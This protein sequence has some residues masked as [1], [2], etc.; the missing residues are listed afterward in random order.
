MAPDRTKQTNMSN[1]TYVC[2]WCFAHL[3]I[4]NSQL[5]TGKEQSTSTRIAMKEKKKK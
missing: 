3:R 4:P 2:L 1:A 5:E